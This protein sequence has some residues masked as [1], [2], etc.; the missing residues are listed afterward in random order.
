MLAPAGICGAISSVG[1]NMLAADGRALNTA[2]IL[3][4]TLFVVAAVTWLTVPALGIRG[5]A[6]GA[7]CGSAFTATGCVMICVRRYAFRPSRCLAMTRQD[8]RFIWRSL[9]ASRRSV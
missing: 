2:C 5:A 6:C 9:G 7:L 3:A 8:V 1:V 4:G